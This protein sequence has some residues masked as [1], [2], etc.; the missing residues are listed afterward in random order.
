MQGRVGILSSGPRTRA[1]GGAETV[2][3]AGH[4]LSS[5]VSVRVGGLSAAGSG[6]WSTLLH[7][8]QRTYRSI[9]TKHRNFHLSSSAFGN[10]QLETMV[11]IVML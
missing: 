8:N 4:H 10:Q 1:C 9:P 2:V 11:M 5:V 6:R 7:L 3:L